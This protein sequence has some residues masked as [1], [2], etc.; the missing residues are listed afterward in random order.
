MAPSP[1]DE[2]QLR[3]VVDPS[4]PQQFS[5]LERAQSRLAGHSNRIALHRDAIHRLDDVKNPQA[6][7]DHRHPPCGVG[8]LQPRPFLR[9][10]QRGRLVSLCEKSND[11]EDVRDQARV[12]EGVQSD[13]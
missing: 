12:M 5:A 6:G 10:L 7:L 2:L 8:D 13:R 3:G 11:H 1:R 4:I 9:L